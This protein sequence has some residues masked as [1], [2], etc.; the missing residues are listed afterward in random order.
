M[1]PFS[2]DLPRTHVHLDSP[3]LGTNLDK[4]YTTYLYYTIIL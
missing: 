1:P 2:C 3:M 4:D